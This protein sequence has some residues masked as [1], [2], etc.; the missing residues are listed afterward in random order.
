MAHFAEIDENN[1]VKRVLVVSNEI[2]Y[3]AEGI[4]KEDLGKNHLQNQLGGNWVQT[5][6]NNNIRKNFAGIGYVYDSVK[7][8][9]IPPQP[10]PSWTLNNETCQWEPPI[11]K[12]GDPKHI[13]TWE[14]REEQQ[15]WEE[16]TPPA[17]PV[18]IQIVREDGN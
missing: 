1:V 15:I 17:E 12:P 6:I 7:D 16:T 8:A 10:F 2:T 11:E 9:F 4:E 14:W 18:L 5:S 3:D 13:R